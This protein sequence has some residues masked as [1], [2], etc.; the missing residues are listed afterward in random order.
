MVDVKYARF[1]S[2]V[3]QLW[4][5][6]RA[7]MA[8]DAAHPYLSLIARNFFSGDVPLGTMS[9]TPAVPE[10]ASGLL[11]GVRGHAAWRLCRRR[12]VQEEAASPNGQR[13]FRPSRISRPHVP[14]TRNRL[15]FAAW[16]SEVGATVRP[17]KRG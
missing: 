2:P 6:W 4:V 17:H 8:L 15:S 12:I 1:F 9:A 7:I 3:L 13:L 16:D 10:Q 5:V 14:K 11:L